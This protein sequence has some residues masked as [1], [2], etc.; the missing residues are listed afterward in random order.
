MGFS[1]GKFG[2][3]FPR[4]SQLQQ[5]RAT[6]PTVHAGC[7][8]V[9]IIHQTVTWTTGPLT[10]AQMSMHVIAHGGCTDTCKRVR[11]ESWPWEKNPL[12]H[13]RIEPASAAWRSDGLTN[14]AT[15]PHNW[16]WNLSNQ[17]KWG[18]LFVKWPVDLILNLENE[19][20]EWWL[21]ES[22]IRKL[23]CYRLQP[24]WYLASVV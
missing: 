17:R 20:H 6:Q 12:P 13:R 18:I 5:S 1:H 11:T 4:E 23:A 15:S 8:T 7:F 24:L 22:D 3:L 2:L 10:C 16:N 21:A 9:S 14:W 19:F